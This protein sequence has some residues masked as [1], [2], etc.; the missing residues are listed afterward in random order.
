M[1]AT[2]GDYV[3]VELTIN[4]KPIETRQGWIKEVFDDGGFMVECVA[5]RSCTYITATGESPNGFF[6][7]IKH[8]P[9]NNRDERR[10]QEIASASL[11]AGAKGRSSGGGSAAMGLSQTAG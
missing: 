2:Q 1:K 9:E 11:P 5:K 10:R 7:V 6:K 4:E 8:N 3:E